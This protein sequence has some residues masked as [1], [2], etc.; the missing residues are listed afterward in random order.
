MSPDRMS[1]P[2]Q[3]GFN[4]TRFGVRVPAVVVSPFIAQGTV[5]R[6]PLST[7]YDHTSVLATLRD[8]L[9]IPAAVMLKSE[10]IVAAPTLEQV[11]TLATPR[12][13]LPAISPPPGV[14]VPANLA[15]PPNDLQRSMI[16]A[17]AQFRGLN[18]VSEVARIRSRQDVL[19]FCNREFPWASAGGP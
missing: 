11:L 10:R 3:E 15:A 12:T 2:G 18:A 14:S 8:W 17:A 9:G 19:D 7:P 4:F 1:N 13:D 6:S 5:F 16:A